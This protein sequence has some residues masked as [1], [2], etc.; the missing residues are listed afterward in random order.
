MRAAGII[1]A[2]V[3]LTAGALVG[4]Y[5][6]GRRSADA[7]PTPNS[8]NV[9]QSP[10]AAG[11]GAA[12]KADRK[13]KYYRHPMGLPDTSP[14][15]KKDPMGMDYIPVY[16]GDEPEAGGPV[17]KISLD[18]VQKLGV[19]TEA[20][21]TRDLTRIVR[22]VGTLQVDERRLSIVSPRFEGYIE[23]LHVNTVGQ[24][25][26]KGQPLMEVYSPELLTAQQEYRIAEQGLSATAEGTEQ[27]R[28][29]MNRLKTGVVERLR[30]WGISE[31]ELKNLGG[32]TGNR[33]ALTLRSPATGVIL[34]KPAV[35]GMRF[36]PGEMLYKIADLSSLWLLAEVFEQD[37]GLIR[38]GQGARIS[39][40]AYPGKEFNGRVAFVYPTLNAETRTALARIELT[41]PAGLLK[42]AMFAS[43]ELAAGDSK[44]R[45]VTVPDSAV[46][47][48]GTRQVV[49]VRRGEGSFEPRTIKSGMRADGYIE[50]IE[51]VQEG[52]QVV[53]RANFLIDAESNLKAALGGFGGHDA[54]GGQSKSK[55]S[56]PSQAAGA[57]VHKGTGTVQ[58]V[59]P[60]GGTVEVNHGPIVSLKWP[61][62]TMQFKVKDKAMLAGINKG[63]AVEIDIVQR[64][65]GEFVIE[66]IAPASA[67]EHKGH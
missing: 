40:T 3:V 56:N 11:S 47:D 39:V 66:R 57:Q 29:A 9:V 52:D 1:V 67:A 24:A 21:S 5:Y 8:Q 54:H 17:V 34:E 13:I 31:E 63:Q 25:V 20:A 51:G 65:P 41:N 45:A 7:P 18:K 2:V 14:V 16:E 33:F 48:S 4:G 43:V 28:A 64:A 44:T 58:A 35:Q 61:S 36:M 53:V 15:P 10:D 22:A 49:L 6:W 62:M 26:I 59:D 30:N 27:T 32:A 50:V 46:L 37:L 19:R 55:P 38:R 42:P 60:G 23:R 12:S